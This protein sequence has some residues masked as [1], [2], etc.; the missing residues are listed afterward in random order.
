MEDWSG[1]IPG[2]KP[3]NIGGGAMTNAPGFKFFVGIDASKEQFDVCCV[4]GTGERLFRL[5]TDMNR[6]GFNEI[7]KKLSV[8]LTFNKSQIY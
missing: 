1:G 4:G 5:S 2:I 8:I 7:T 3:A 6:T